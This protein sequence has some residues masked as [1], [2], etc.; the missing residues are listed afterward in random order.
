MKRHPVMSLDDVLVVGFLRDNVAD[1]A[2]QKAF[3]MPSSR[4]LLR[5]KRKGPR[6]FSPEVLDLD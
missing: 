3:W 1:F 5:R 4:Q 2:L 6:T